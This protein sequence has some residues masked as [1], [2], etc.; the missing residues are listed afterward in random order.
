MPGGGLHVSQVPG[1]SFHAW[2]QLSQMVLLQI[3]TQSHTR[4]ELYN[5]MLIHP[6]KNH[7]SFLIVHCN[8][9]SFIPELVLWR[10]SLCC[11][12]DA[13]FPLCSGSSGGV[14]TSNSLQGLRCL[15]VPRG[16]CCKEEEGNTQLKRC[17]R[18]CTYVQDGEDSC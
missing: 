4:G 7:E 18:E 15:R 12:A 10:A 1:L 8:L 13:A 17:H 2:T 5:V 11:S 6:H 14:L 9:K 16:L 3:W